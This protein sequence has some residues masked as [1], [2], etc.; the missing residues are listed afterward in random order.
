MNKSKRTK[1]T[2]DFTAR[3]RQI[4][5]VLFTVFYE[6]DWRLTYRP[7]ADENDADN[8]RWQFVDAVIDELRED[9]A[10]RARKKRA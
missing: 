7:P 9:R 10:K 2:G 1:K 4:R 5:E 8:E 6:R 3:E